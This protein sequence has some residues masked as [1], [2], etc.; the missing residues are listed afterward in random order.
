MNNDTLLGFLLALPLYGIILL[1]FKDIIIHGFL[2]KLVANSKTEIAVCLRF[3]SSFLEAGL[4]VFGF[5]TD[6]FWITLCISIGLTEEISLS[7][8]ER[9]LTKLSMLVT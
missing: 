3:L 6:S 4:P 5:L 1:L 8:H 9:W 2:K 7:M